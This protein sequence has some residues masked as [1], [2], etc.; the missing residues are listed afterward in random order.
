MKREPKNLDQFF[1]QEIAKLK[2][3]ENMEKGLKL[4]TLI[5][6]Q[7][8]ISLQQIID[9]LMEHFNHLFLHWY[10]H[11]REMFMYLILYRL[12]IAPSFRLK[13]SST[14]LPIEKDIYNKYV[15]IEYDTQLSK[16]VQSKIKHLKDVQK[17]K[18]EMNETEKKLVV[19][20][21]QSLKEWNCLENE[22]TKWKEKNVY[23]P[24]KK[25][26]TL[27]ELGSLENKLEDD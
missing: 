26:M 3:E 15:N 12:T 4:K 18:A 22:F 1:A 13:S 2:N 5:E 16:S 25:H 7:T 14:L 10:S 11:V 27:D 19:Y 17:G 21:K 6:E 9:I 8:I 23:H 24:P 20:I